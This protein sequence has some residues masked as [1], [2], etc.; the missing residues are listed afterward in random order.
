MRAKLLQLKGK[1]AEEHSPE[2]DVFVRW[3][4]MER[5]DARVHVL[6]A[7]DAVAA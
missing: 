6:V 4:G 1:A 5:D 2:G 7:R 3:A